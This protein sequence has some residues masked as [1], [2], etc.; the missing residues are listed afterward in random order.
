MKHNKMYKQFEDLYTPSENTKK[1][2][3]ELLINAVLTIKKKEYE[4]DDDILMRDLESIQKSE[5]KDKFVMDTIA[6]LLKSL[7]LGSTKNPVSIIPSSITMWSDVFENLRSELRTH[8][9]SWKLLHQ[10]Y[11]KTPPLPLQLYKKKYN[12][13]QSL[14]YCMASMIVG[15]L[16]DDTDVNITWGGSNIK[17]TIPLTQ[18]TP[19]LMALDEQY[20]CLLRLAPYNDF[21][22]HSIYPPDASFYIV[23]AWVSSSLDNDIK[24]MWNNKA[25]I[26]GNI[27]VKIAEDDKEM[28]F[29]ACKTKHIR[30]LRSNIHV[31]P[32]LM[33][34][35][36]NQT[37][38]SK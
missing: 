23:Y 6:F 38:I 35:G 30:V 15:F 20:P 17:Q 16:R 31:L 33:P 11:E 13:D 37:G 32:S 36:N 10:S 19:F 21:K 29:E 14:R 25:Y 12:K 5:N 18:E 9:N 28:F 27:V 7:N 4:K 1:E 34:T 3:K 22:I 8:P 2:M 24:F 26:N